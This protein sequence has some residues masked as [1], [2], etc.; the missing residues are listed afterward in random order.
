MQD[1]FKLALRGTFDPV[2]AAKR[3]VVLF[4]GVI[5]LLSIWLQ[6]QGSSMVMRALAGTGYVCGAYSIVF[7]AVF[8]AEYFYFTSRRILRA[9][10]V[11][12][13]GIIEQLQVF[14]DQGKHWVKVCEKADPE[15]YPGVRAKDWATSTQNYMREN[16]GE[17]YVSRFNDT[18]CETKKRGLNWS[19]LPL[20]EHQ[21]QLAHVASINLGNIVEELIADRS[22][23]VR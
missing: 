18:S 10:A 7:A 4:T 15:S 23:Q 8:A 22:S 1:R 20:L 19:D 9:A 2:F 5:W 12:K 16:L 14:L 13:H 17:E 6:P 21:R 3:L 11:R